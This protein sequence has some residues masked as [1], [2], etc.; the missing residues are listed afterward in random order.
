MR[1]RRLR[2]LVLLVLGS[3]GTAAAEQSLTRSDDLVERGAY[4]VRAAGCARCHTADPSKPFAGGVSVPSAVGAIVAP[5]ITPDETAGIGRWSEEQ[6]LKAVRE[7]VAPDGSHLYPA[8][9][10]DF[11]ARMAPDDALAIRA[12]LMAQRPVPE[13]APATALTFPLDQ[14][15][16]IG[17][18]KALNGRAARFVPH[19]DRSP[20]WNRGAYLVEAL[21]HCGQCHTPATLAF[22]RDRRRPLAGGTVG[23][24]IAY[25]ITSD[26]EGGIGG[27]SEND[28][29]RYLS[30]GAAP[31]RAYAAGPMAEVI[32][33]GLAFLTE[34]DVRAIVAFLREVPAAARP[35]EAS[36][37][38][39]FGKPSSA[40]TAF[41]GTVPVSNDPVRSGAELYSGACASCHG[42]DGAGSSDGT[43][44]SLFRNTLTGAATST[45]LV[46]T[47]LDG[48]DRR[49]GP[50]RV[51]MPGYR[52]GLTDEQVAALA[53][54]V[55]RSF[56]N[57]AAATRPETVAVLRAG[58]QPGD[59][60]SRAEAAGPAVALF[61]AAVMAGLFLRLLGRAKRTKPA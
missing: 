51:L 43:Y 2:V 12:F 41:R 48:V 1:L 57:P 44:P 50:H 28:L 7:G 55:A 16:L 22:G 59:W 9:P 33:H 27:W 53:T 31:G 52:A 39:N 25:D 8:M 34:E 35:G 49:I 40:E 61:V 11:Y 24:W 6:F 15:W 46:M 47:I 45:N 30:T 26:A 13:P 58:R 20:A 38:F 4:L 3:V 56:G 18:W 60:R 23:P 29:V 17:V 14:R 37:R 32:E 36:A 21:G 42:S 5:N 10:Y 19:A 54:Y